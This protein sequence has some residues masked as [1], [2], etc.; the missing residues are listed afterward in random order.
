MLMWF[1]I[2]FSSG[3][4]FVRTLYHDLSVLGGPTWHGSYRLWSM[5][6]FWLVFCDC[7]FL[8]VCPLMEEE[9][10]FVHTFWPEGLTVG[11]AG[12]YSVC[13]AMLSKSLESC[14]LYARAIA[15]V[16]GLMRT[17]SKRTCVNMLSLQEYSCHCPWP[18]SRPLLNRASTLDSQTLT[19]KSSCLLW[20]L[21]FILLSP[22]ICKVLFVPSKSLCF[23]SPVEIL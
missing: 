10:R 4:H 12:S 21:C 19:G 7:V 1:A 16:L 2:P 17:S 20:G 3:P 8:S 5:C 18:R 23:P 14:I 22:G 6:S 15:S 11:K 9:K 13:R